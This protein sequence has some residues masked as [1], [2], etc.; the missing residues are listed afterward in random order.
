MAIIDTAAIDHLRQG[1]YAHGKFDRRGVLP[2]LGP[3]ITGSVMIQ[4]TFGQPKSFSDNTPFNDLSMF[5]AVT[6]LNDVDGTMVFPQIL[7][8]VNIPDPSQMDGV[9][10]PLVIRGKASLTTIEHPGVA[11]DIK[12][13]LC[14][15]NEDSFRKT[16]RISGIFS[17]QA[18]AV[19]EPFID[20]DDHLGATPGTAVVL[21]GFFPDD[22]KVI[23]PFDDTQEPGIS[24]YGVT[25]AGP[26]V[27]TDII[28]AMRPF[29]DDFFPGF[30]KS[31]GAG[32]TY[33]GSA[34]GTDSIAFGGL[35]R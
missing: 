3:E 16:D 10:E 22:E 2:A 34:P 20:S 7:G 4:T 18:S 24:K 32:F 6:F 14:G 33:G 23:G 9:L 12:G 28:L 27:L 15:G 25:L 17:V 1:V 5:D 8:N 31:A 26:V 21:P 11:H 29:T 30:S 19:V 13:C 35:T